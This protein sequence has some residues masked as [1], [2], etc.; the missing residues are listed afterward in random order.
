MEVGHEKEAFIVVLESYAVIEG[1][2]QVAQ[3]K[4]SCGTVPC[5]EH[6]FAV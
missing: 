1:A 2:N 6:G 4:A 3:M 5:N